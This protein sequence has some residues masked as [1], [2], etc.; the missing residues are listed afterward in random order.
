MPSFITRCFVMPSVLIAV[1]TVLWFSSLPAQEGNPPQGQNEWAEPAVL[2]A[3]SL[4]PDVAAIDGHA[5]AVGER[6]HV[7]VSDDAGSNWHQAPRVPTRSMLT[8]VTMIDPSNAWSVGHDA[9]ILHSTDGGETWRRQFFEPDL[10]SPLFDVWFENASHGIAVGAY[11]LL[12]VTQNGG[13]SWEQRLIDEE[14]RHWNAITPGPDGMLY[15]AAEFGVIFR[16]S[17]KGKNWVVLST[18]YEGT[19]FGTLVLSDGALLIFGLR[20]NIYR[21]IDRGETWQHIQTDT[22]VS[23]LN[24]L[25]RSDKRVVI[26]GLSGT[27]L[28]SRDLGKSFKSI[29]RSDRKGIAAVIETEDKGLLLFG[30]GGVTPSNSLLN[31]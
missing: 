25:E 3:N 24:G 13:A 16:S 4:L 1:S 8:S 5:I 27:I 20:G 15:V 19:F 22:S 12:L 18:P 9:V 11:G 14:E 28:F 31:R 6:G 7:L 30:E 17:D 23:L 10:E 26:V 21:S 29:N 2:A